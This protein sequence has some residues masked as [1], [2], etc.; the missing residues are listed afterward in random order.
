GSARG[1]P[2]EVSCRLEAA[3]FRPRE[4]A[5]FT[6]GVWRQGG[7]ARPVTLG[8]VKQE[9]DE[10]G[11]ARLRCPALTGA[12][13]FKG[14]ARLVAQAA[15]FESGSGRSTQGELDVP[16]HPERYYLGVQSGARKV[17]RG[18][19]FPVSGAV[20][21]WDGKLLSSGAVKT[22]EVEYSRLET[23]YGYFWDEEEGSERYQRFLRPVR[24]GR[25]SVPVVGGRFQLDVTP[26]ASSASYLVRVRSGGAQTDLVLEGEW[27]D[28]YWGGERQV[29]QTPRPLRATTLPLELPSRVRVGEDIQVKLKA[30]YKGRVLL[31]AETDRVLTA[32]WREVEAGEQTWSFELSELAPNVYVSAFLVKDPHLES[33]EAFLPDRAFGVASVPVEPTA[34]TQALK[35]EVPKEV[36]SNDTLTVQ[37][38]V[39]KLEGPTFATVAAVDEGIL[40]LTRFAS[41]DPLSELFNKRALGV[42]TY[43]T[44]GWTLLVPPQ[45]NSRS[46]GGDGEGGGASG[47]VQPVRPVALWSGVVPVPE[48]G[49]ATV[50]FR[51]PQYRGQLRV[52]AVTTGPRRVGHASA[53]VLVRDPITL[54]TTLPRFLSSLDTFQ[55]PVFVTN[56]SGKAMDV[57]VSL[58]AQNLPVPGLAG[59]AGE[60]S[61]LELLGRR[62][63]SV[64]LEN[65]KSSTLVFQARATR[66]I[67]AA[68]LEVKARGGGFETTESLDVPFSPAGPRER[69]VQR[70]E[71]AEGATDLKPFLAGWTPT[72][73]RSTIWVTSNPYGASFDHLK[74]VVQYPH[75]CIEQ[76][77]SSTRPMLF[78]S[79]LLESVDPTL[80]A[81]RKVEEYVTAGVR[82]ILAMQTPAGGF[83]YWPGATEPVAWGTAYATHLLLDAQKAGYPVPQDRLDE[84]LAWAG[85]ELTRYEQRTALRDGYYQ[86]HGGDAEPYLH[87]VL[88]RAGKGRKGA[89]QKLVDALPKDGRDGQK[90]E[91]A[92]VLKAAL[93]LA[94]DRRH[95]R[96]LRNPDVTPVSDERRNSWSFY[97]DRRRRGLVLSTFEDLFPGDAAGEPLANL[98]AQALSGQP[99]A[100]Y[101]TQE[102]VWGVTGLGKRVGSA[103]A[104]FGTPVLTAAG[105]R[106]E[107]K[108]NPRVKSSE[109]TWALAR[110]SE[111]GSLGVTVERKGEGKVYAIVSS[112]GVRENGSYRL[113]GQGLSVTRRYRKLDGQPVDVRNEPVPLAQM[114]FVEIEVKNTTGERV[115][116]LALVDR[117]PAGWEIENPRLGR[118]VPVDWV[119]RDALWAADSLNVRDDRLEMFGALE[120]GQTRKVVYAVRAV[121]AGTF[122]LPPVEVEAMYDPRIW[123]REAGGQVEVSGPWK[124]FL[125]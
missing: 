101:T 2:V 9:L 123:A 58:A 61:P 6:Y 88:A 85:G 28:W 14:A 77:T 116:N 45:G 69:M 3:T 57:K 20:V 87:Y 107:A 120:R 5:Q 48:S 72:T 30:P 26:Q 68:R 12:G 55:V 78:V 80:V 65:G 36:R 74:H 121:T 102:L 49:K 73:E 122:T 110:A 81:D 40:Q 11:H 100:Y 118:G 32:E 21:D 93:Y 71:L 82:R 98:V 86:D 25:T 114:L 7:D 46:T 111:Y 103:R 1:S 41:P 39:G 97:S 79:G 44:V 106:V 56:L 34:F 52:M 8:Q 50:T 54:Q 18:K 24:E 63:G 15:V 115:Q 95:E 117:L 70:I 27:T 17:S 29:D 64:H 76:T 35:L 124:D 94:G 67:G 59:S 89:I 16:V 75:G 96:D 53:Q 84:A 66:S 51:V 104:S 23:E 4:N 92:Y 47:R 90:L 113:G 108:P 22:V 42:E 38:D 37:L 91:H 43:E 109:R 112:E 62:E 83:G 99:S 105:K 125:L 19:P 33:K 13:G 10:K 60:D 119:D 31:T